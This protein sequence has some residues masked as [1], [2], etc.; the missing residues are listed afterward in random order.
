MSM[1][2]K[3]CFNEVESII[4]LLIEYLHKHTE[5]DDKLDSYVLIPDY[6]IIK[7]KHYCRFI[8]YIQ[9]S[10][11]KDVSVL[12][13]AIRS[14]FVKRSITFSQARNHIREAYQKWANEKEVI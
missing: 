14:I 11:N 6:V 3:V 1:N 13:A 7:V 5:T 4:S 12:T 2:C 9:P 10:C 8:E